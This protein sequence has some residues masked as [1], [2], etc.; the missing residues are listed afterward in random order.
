M[1]H[2]NITIYGRVQGVFF[3]DSAKKEADKLDLTGFVRN[4][5]AGSV[6]IEAEGEEKDLKKFLDWC[7][8]G[9]RRAEVKKVDF[10]FSDEVKNFKEFSVKL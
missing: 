1:K 2:V 4:E 9:P 10:E 5:S 7:W 6:Y 8:S 3:R